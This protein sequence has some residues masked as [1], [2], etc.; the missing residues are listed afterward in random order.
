MGFS[1]DVNKGCVVLGC[2]V[3]VLIGGV[4]LAVTILLLGVV[5]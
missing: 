2:A 4:A 5:R 3:C 1:Y